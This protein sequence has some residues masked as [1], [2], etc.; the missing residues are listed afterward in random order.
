ML[1]AFKDLDSLGI[2]NI[3]KEDFVAV[4]DTNDERP[5]PGIMFFY[6]TKE[7]PAEVDLSVRDFLN[8][9][10]YKSIS[11]EILP[12][13]LEIFE[14]GAVGNLSEPAGD[15]VSI[16]A[17]W[18]QGGD[19][20]YGSRFNNQPLT[21][22]QNGGTYGGKGGS[23]GDW[24]QDGTVGSASTDGGTSGLNT[25]RT[26]AGLSIVDW[27]KYALSGSVAGNTKGRIS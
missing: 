26:L 20:G 4:V 16:T 2:N 3:K 23:G 7:M 5:E 19:G 8:Y 1:Y 11:S 13:G 12:M 17:I 14:P 25:G 27:S 24:G 10:F 21:S 22:G 9:G 15:F 18:G 6:I